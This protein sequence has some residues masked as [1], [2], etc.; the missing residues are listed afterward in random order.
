MRCYREEIK[1]TQIY[2]SE[3]HRYIIDKCKENPGKAITNF[4]KS[5]IKLMSI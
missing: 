3:Q 2:A 4:N 1:K 5:K